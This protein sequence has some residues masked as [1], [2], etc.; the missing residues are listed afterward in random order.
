MVILVTHKPLTIMSSYRINIRYSFNKLIIGV[1]SS[2][3]D[4]EQFVL[5]FELIQTLPCVNPLFL[6]LFPT[7]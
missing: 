4:F 7:W 5:R 2:I 6:K 3:T 1:T